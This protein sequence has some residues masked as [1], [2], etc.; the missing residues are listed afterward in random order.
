[1]DFNRARE[2]FEKKYLSFHYTKAAGS[3]SR[4]APEI[5]MTPGNIYNKLRRYNITLE[6]KKGS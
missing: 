6:E 1:M 4:M 5:G 2:F 3:V